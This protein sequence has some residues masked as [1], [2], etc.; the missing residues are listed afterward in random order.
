MKERNF[1]ER[2]GIV[3]NRGLKM[4]EASWQLLEFL[5]CAIEQY[6]GLLLAPVQ[7]I[8]NRLKLAVDHHNFRRQR[9]NRTGRGRE[10]WESLYDS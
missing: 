3:G 8:G 10:R 4:R 6:W 2:V 1:G 7:P 5:R 9:D